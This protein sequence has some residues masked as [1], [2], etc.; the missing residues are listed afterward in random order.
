M[1]TP[2]SQFAFGLPLALL[3]AHFLGDF[4]LQTDWMAI[5]KSKRWDALSA[6]A[7]VYSMC[8]LPWGITF[9]LATFASH[10]ATDAVTSRITSKLWFFRMEPG[11]WEQADYAVPKHGRTLVN[12]WTPRGGNRHWFFVVIGLD[13]LIH[14]TT[15]ALTLAY[16]AR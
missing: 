8:F 10:Y 2:I 16:V 12:P 1:I 7:F 11:I 6:H 4:I 5:N 3:V 14:A 13:Q 9:A 15:L